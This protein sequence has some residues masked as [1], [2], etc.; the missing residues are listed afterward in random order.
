MSLKVI[1]G[2]CIFIVVIAICFETIDGT[3]VPAAEPDANPGYRRGNYRPY[4]NVRPYQVLI[5]Q[6]SYYRPPPVVYRPAPVFYRPVGHN[7][8]H[9]Y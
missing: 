8:W 5:V 6:P 2:L 3:P 1:C 7:H 4:P 9:H